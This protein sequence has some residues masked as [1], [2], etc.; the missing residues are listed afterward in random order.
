MI[1]K[2][3]VKDGEVKIN[4]LIKKNFSEEFM[5]KIYNIYNDDCMSIVEKTIRFDRIFTEEFGKRKDYRRIGEGTN[6]F[7]CL[8]DNHIIKVA[9]NYLAYIDNMNELAQ[10]KNKPKYLAKAY[11]T[12]GL[13]LVSEYV[14]V[15]DKEE[16]IENSRAIE[17]ILTA[18]RANYKS[19]DK[20][21]NTYYILG[22]MGKSEKN[23]GNWGRRMN[24]EIV[25]LDYG[26]LYEVKGVDWIEV[27][28]CPACG[29]DLDYT[30]D[31]SEL[32]CCKDGCPTKV[33]YTTLR[34]NLGYGKIIE[35]IKENLNKGKVTKFDKDGTVV[36]DVMKEETYDDEP[37]TVFEMP[38]EIEYKLKFTADKFIDVLNHNR[39]KDFN[40]NYYGNEIREDLLNNKDLYDEMLFPFIVGVVD[41][42]EVNI[43]RY[44]EDFD[45]LYQERYNSL[46]NELKKEDDSKDLFTKEVEEFTDYIDEETEELLN[47]SFNT[48]VKNVDRYSENNDVK[49]VT[50]LDDIL[51]SIVDDC[52]S[53]LIMVDES[54][55][56]DNIDD[57]MSFDRLLEIL[58][59]EKM[60]N[61]MQ[62][63]EELSVED[64]LKLAYNKLLDSLTELIYNNYIA[65]N[66]FD[67]D[68]V[69]G[70]EDRV[71]YNGEKIDYDYSPRVN[72]IN[73]LGK[74]DVDNF[75]F[76]LYRHLLIKHDYDTDVVDYEFEAIYNI[77]GKIE[78]PKDIYERIENRNIT[79]EQ[80]M[81]RF[82]DH[83]PQKTT[84]INM[85]GKQLNDYYQAVDNYYDEKTK[86]ETKS[87]YE[88]NDYYLKAL[89]PNCEVS[90]LIRDAKDDLIDELLNDGI[91]Y[92]DIKDEYDIVYYYDLES[93]MTNTELNMLDVIRNTK[94]NINDNI[95]DVTLNRY[96]EEYNSILNDSMFDIFKYNGSFVKETG[97]E[98]C[99]RET[100]PTIKAKLV[101]KDSNEDRYKPELFNKK[102]FRSINIER[103]YDV[104]L[105]AEDGSEDN[106]TYI[107][108]KS[109]LKRKGLDYS[110]IKIYKYIV[111]NT[112]ENL[113]Y[114]MTEREIE[115][116]NKFNDMLGLSNV[117]D[118]EKAFKKGIYEVL[119][120]EYNFS[121]ETKI[122]MKDLIEF[123][124]SEAFANR[125]LKINLLEMSGSMLR[126]EYLNH[127]EG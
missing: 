75:A 124:L 40:D 31:F 25:V 125:L 57:T 28:K 15:M 45:K 68:Y 102:M 118:V 78:R 11:E 6:R 85:L 120:N 37:E 86:T 101:L 41:V 51:G 56:I 53:N 111:K 104:L 24:G 23:Y 35:N 30:T 19:K 44:K 46:Y 123:G 2:R 76:P 52:F 3:L 72:A 126:V 42:E 1:R 74:Y 73:I 12:N 5:R 121:N 7:V 69:E 16:F 66:H 96:Y 79:I 26:Y 21:K 38:E 70:D 77:D 29:S 88:D 71:L 62:D 54:K 13:I 94:F 127:I 80:I 22:D 105:E 87:S 27:A 49:K 8:L 89:N 108:L 59:E 90:K 48:T 114:G 60:E 110:E 82:E 39:G 109:N 36:V 98:L 117:K 43:E 33:K 65:T 112:N 50:D 106:S 122:F 92:S 95:K 18:L 9:Y 20:T 67:D 91:K 63:E 17:N 55:E 93:I 107:N 84:F 113:R 119:N 116:V 99:R 81:T 61:E 32:E 97:V 115:I 100:R 64:E 83:V 47:Q 103:R 4:S 14:T 10:A 34:N 58:D